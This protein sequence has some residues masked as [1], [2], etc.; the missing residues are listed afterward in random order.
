VS[1]SLIFVILNAASNASGGKDLGQLRG[2][3][4]GS[5][6]ESLHPMRMANAHATTRPE[7][8]FAIFRTGT[9]GAYA[10]LSEILLAA[11]VARFVRMTE[12]R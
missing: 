7:D 5:G 3:E 9:G 6:F 11:R 8:R 12:Q 4:G 1:A 10:P 2:S